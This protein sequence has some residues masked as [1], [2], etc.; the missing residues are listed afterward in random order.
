LRVLSPK[1]ALQAQLAYASKINEKGP[2]STFPYGYTQAAK[3]PV[4]ASNLQF[5]T[6][7]RRYDGLASLFD[8]QRPTSMPLAHV[9]RPTSSAIPLIGARRTAPNAQ[10]SHSAKR[11]TLNVQVL[12]PLRYNLTCTSAIPALCLLSPLALC[13]LRPVP[14]YRVAPH[15]L[16]SRSA[17]RS[18]P[19]HRYPIPVHQPLASWMGWGHG[20]PFHF[21]ERMANK[22]RP[23]LKN[24]TGKLCEGLGDFSG[25]SGNGT[26]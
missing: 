20:F 1:L 16:T 8:V 3:T 11:P 21:S 6:C 5:L 24:E 13:A 17:P 14:N 15:A 7:G 12:Q 2:Y 25:P 23:F 26:L 10:P 22:H 9:H 18:T 19:H 4:K